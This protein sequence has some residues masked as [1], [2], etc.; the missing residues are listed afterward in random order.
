MLATRG[1]T[2]M[3][4]RSFVSSPSDLLSYHAKADPEWPQMARNK[5]LVDPT[6]QLENRMV[7]SLSTDC[8][9]TTDVAQAR[10]L[11]TFYVA[12]IVRAV[13]STPVAYTTMH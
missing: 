6:S 4:E 8:T 1:G 7:T 5:I 3:D 2:L 9:L 12:L 11:N 13:P 10:G